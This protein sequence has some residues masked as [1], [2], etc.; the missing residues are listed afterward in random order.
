M[1]S[2]K[3][4]LLTAL[5]FLIP[6]FGFSQTGPAGIGNSS[7]N[8]IWLR[9]DSGVYS[10]AGTTPAVNFSTVQEWHDFSGNGNDAIQNT[11]AFRPEFQTNQANGNPALNFDGI[12][13]RI[14]SS[15]VGTSNQACVAVVINWENPTNNNDG[16]IHAAPSGNEFSTSANDKSI[17]MW[18][19]SSSSSPWGRG[20]QSN[21]STRSIPTSVSISWGTNTFYVI[22][23]NYDGSD[24]TQYVSGSTSGSISYNGTLKDWSEFGIGR[25]G[26]ESFNGDITEVIAYTTALNSAQLII[27]QNSLKAKYGFSL[28]S[29]SIYDMDTP[30]NGDFDHEVAGI[31]RVDASNL[32]T[33]AQG[34]GIVQVTK[35][36][37]GLGNNEFLIWGHDNGPLNSFG[38][39]D[40]PSGVEARLGRIWRV[41]EQGEPG[42]VEIAFDLT[43]LGPVTTSDLRLLIDT[44]GDG[45]FSDADVISGATSLGGN[46][47][48]FDTQTNNTLE[49]ADMFTIATINTSQTPLPITLVS[50]EAKLMQN[51]VQLSWATVS[52]INNDY[53]SIERSKD[54]KN[55]IEIGTK[56]GAGTTSKR[57]TYQFV[58]DN[59]IEGNSYYRLKQTDYDGKYT[60]SD[61]ESIY[62][63]NND[64]LVN[65]YPNPLSIGQEFKVQV[66]DLIQGIYEC[67]IYSSDGKLLRRNQ[68]EVKDDE[69]V[70]SPIFNSGT[71]IINLSGPEFEWKGKVIVR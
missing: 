43:G 8:E 19:E 41:T 45:D 64:H 55:W 52:E 71:Y 29:N 67:R 11:S 37:G 4:I 57:M 36:G 42:S 5:Q 50:F 60:Y 17:G 51:I 12:N 40:V 23:N 10:D 28:L 46:M 7:T 13:D 21:N 48:E 63:S 61:L 65:T 27:L 39:T 2:L 66:P 34:S 15:G 6:F 68:L 30:A 18:A 14:L 31:G 22:I 44:D 24:I 16:I 53:F 26:N 70:L 59:P 47:Y 35:S 25:Q 1:R 33:V 20:V 3:L 54:G 49:D 9:S 58:D 38:Y 69:I 56:K 32:H 62:F